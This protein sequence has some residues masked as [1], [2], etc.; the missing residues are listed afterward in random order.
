LVIY[1]SDYFSPV[2]N[3]QLR[4]DGLKSWIKAQAFK[5]VVVVG[6]SAYFKL[7]LNASSKMENCHIETTI[8]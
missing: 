7:W 6:H 8:L 1:G 5:E 2:E 3:L 4:I